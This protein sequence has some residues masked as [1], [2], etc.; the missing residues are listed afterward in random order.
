[1]FSIMGRY[2]CPAASVPVDGA[3][4]PDG[5]GNARRAVATSNGALVQATRAP[6]RTRGGRHAPLGEQRLGGE[7]MSREYHFDDVVAGGGAAD[8]SVAGAGQAVSKSCSARATQNETQGASARDSEEPHKTTEP[9]A[10]IQVAVGSSKRAPVTET[11]RVAGTGTEPH[12]AWCHVGAASLM[13]PPGSIDSTGCRD[14]HQ[15]RG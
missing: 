4:Y 3:D 15:P 9:A 10:T 14:A 6:R 13:S 11:G 2:G 1:L 8:P 7:L 12:H 5:S